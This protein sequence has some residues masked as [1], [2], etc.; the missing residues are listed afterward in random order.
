MQSP[1]EA[2]TEEEYVKLV[3]SIDADHPL[4]AGGDLEIEECAGGAC[5]IR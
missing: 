4:T 3:M 2:I 5:P 1:Y